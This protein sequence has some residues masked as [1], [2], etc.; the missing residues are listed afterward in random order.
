LGFSAFTVTAVTSIRIRL[1]FDFKSLKREK[2]NDVYDRASEHQFYGKW[3]FENL[4]HV[5]GVISF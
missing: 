5:R 4:L 1:S 3:V 2:E